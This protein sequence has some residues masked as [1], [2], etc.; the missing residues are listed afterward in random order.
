MAFPV[1]GLVFHFSEKERRRTIKE[2][3]EQTRSMARIHP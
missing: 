2:E 1:Y 3:A